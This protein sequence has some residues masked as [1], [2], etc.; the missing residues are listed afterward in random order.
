MGWIAFLIAS[1]GFLPLL[2]H[3]L[4]RTGKVASLVWMALL[5]VLAVIGFLTKP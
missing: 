5:V 3:F 2:V 1:L 4:P